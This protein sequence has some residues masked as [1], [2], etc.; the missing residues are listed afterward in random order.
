MA[1]TVF[2]KQGEWHSISSKKGIQLLNV[3]FDVHISAQSRVHISVS[4]GIRLR[5]CH[6]LSKMWNI[7]NAI[8]T[9]LQMNIHAHKF[10]VLFKWIRY[11]FI[12]FFSFGILWLMAVSLSFSCHFHSY[13]FCSEW[14]ISHAIYH[15]MGCFVLLCKVMLSYIWIIYWDFS[16]WHSKYS[17]SK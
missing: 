17:K 14:Q 10:M 15:V 4:W 2:F 13:M 1:D 12:L 6:I 11:S 9:S 16:L 5:K 7:H 3:S 8:L